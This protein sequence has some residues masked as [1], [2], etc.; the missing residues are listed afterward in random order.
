M[1]LNSRTGYASL[2]FHIIFDDNF[3]MVSCLDSSIAPPNWDVLVQKY[4]ERDCTEFSSITRSWNQEVN[5]DSLILKMKPQRPIL[6]NDLD[7]T[8]DFTSSF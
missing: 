6:S 1:D 8:I 5:H 4:L 7:V 2:Q 3:S